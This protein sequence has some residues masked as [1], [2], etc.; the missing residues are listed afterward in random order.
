MK[1]GYFHLW[2]KHV[3]ESAQHSIFVK[4]NGDTAY[5]VPSDLSLICLFFHKQEAYNYRIVI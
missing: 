4:Y 3:Q 1:D 5:R 2:I